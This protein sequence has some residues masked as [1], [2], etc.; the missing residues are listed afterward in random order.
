MDLNLNRLREMHPLLAYSTAAEYAH[1]AAIGLGRHGHDPGVN[2][3]VVFDDQ[4]RQSSLFW[5]T[6]PPSAAAQLD[7]NRVTEDAAE[8]I[9]LAV[10][11]VANGWVALR[12]LQQRQFADWLLVDKEKNLVA[13][14]VSGVDTVDHSGRR[15]KQKTD[16]VRKCKATKMRAACVVELQAPRS[17]MTM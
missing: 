2:H 10:A 12:R 3:N 16:Q 4:T 9:A 6:V 17:R 1:R 11:S 15:L 8:A 5:I 14:E 7:F 13:L